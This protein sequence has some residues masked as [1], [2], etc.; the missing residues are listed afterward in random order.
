MRFASSAAERAQEAMYR[1]K[2]LDLR[3]NF[4]VNVSENVIGLGLGSTL[5][6]RDKSK[7][8]AGIRKNL[9]KEKRAGNR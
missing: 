1:A 8:L 2:D 7:E 3:P 5:R 6:E 4:A 9:G